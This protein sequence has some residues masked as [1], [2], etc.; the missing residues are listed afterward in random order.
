MRY[1]SVFLICVLAFAG[2]K[3]RKSAEAASAQ[4]HSRKVLHY[5]NGAEPQFIDPQL[6]TGSPEQAITRALF[7]G[8]LSRSP[9]GVSVAP[10]VAERWEVSGDKLTY[11]FHLRHTARWSDG[12][13]LIAADFINSYKRMLTPGVAADYSYMMFLVAG[14]EDYFNGKIKDFSETG[15][16]ALDDYTLQIVLRQPAPY[17]LN[18][19]IHHAWYPVPTH[20]IEKFGGMSS[21]NTDWTRPGNFVGNGPFRLKEWHLNQ[22]L[23]VEKSPT[24]WD[25]QNVRLDEIVFNPTDLADTA[26]RMFRA[27][28][29]DVVYEVPLSK[30]AT[31]KRERP[32]LLRIEPFC[33][34]YFYRLNTARKPLDDVRVRRALSLAIDRNSIVKNVTLGGEEPAY[35]FV[36]PG[37]AG[38]NSENKVKEDAAEARRLLAEAGYPNGTNFPK[39]DLLFNTLEKHRV[40]G[41]AIQQMWRKNLGI[42]INLYNEEWK[43]YLVS[44]KTSNYTIM[45]SAWIGDYADPHVFLDLWRTGGANNNTNWGDP[46]YDRLLDAALGSKTEEERYATYQKMEKILL[47]SAVVIPIYFYNYVRL[48]DTKVIGFH[49]TYLDDYPWKYVDLRE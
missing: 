1:V 33:G 41:E 40:I 4:T 6:S 34:V 11:T 7:E 15:F 35:N 48:I 3:P 29:L 18:A 10:G 12:K 31:Y 9:D 17:F 26:E 23:V 45:R 16:K 38:F 46:E 20:V 19:V 30:I 36:P 47:D 32:E 14:A 39:V 5:G 42:E 13:P 44:Q 28:Q 49:T 37:L 21:R 27:G 2:C 43:V 25:K 24:Y 8:L 22:R